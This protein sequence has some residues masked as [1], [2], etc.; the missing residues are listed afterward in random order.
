MT[1][2][3]W[4]GHYSQRDFP[5]VTGYAPCNL[6]QPTA[7]LICFTCLDS[8]V[9]LYDVWAQAILVTQNE[10]RQTDSLIT[11]REMLKVG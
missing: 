10:D 3:V 6:P 8:Q 4:E 2:D 9:A 11:K 1:W 5:P 7:P